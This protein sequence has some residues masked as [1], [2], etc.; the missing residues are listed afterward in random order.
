MTPASSTEP[1][2]GA[3]VWASGS[4]VWNGHIGTLTANP[5]PTAANTI[6]WN[7]C[8]KPP[9]A[10]NRVSWTTSNVCTPLPTSELK[11]IARKPSSM[12]TDPNNVYRKNLIAAYSRFELPQIPIRKYIGTRT[13]SQKT[14]NRIRSNATNVPAIP[15]SS[16]S[17]SARNAFVLPGF[18]TTRQ[19]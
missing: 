14:K 13:S 15:V 8:E 19:V 12:N 7:A 9:V 6:S 5:S 17:I 2:V 11:Y 4:H 1:I 18:G 10:A 3:S 16:R